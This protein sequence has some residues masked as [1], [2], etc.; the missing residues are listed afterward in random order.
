MNDEC[1]G[2]EC[3]A[4][5]HPTKVAYVGVLG[6]ESGSREVIIW[7]FQPMGVMVK[8]AVDAA[9]KEFPWMF[10]AFDGTV[11]PEARAPGADDRT[12]LRLECPLCGLTLTRRWPDPRLQAVV[13][14]VLDA[15]VSRL[16]LSDLVA[17]L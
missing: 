1:V 7:P 12:R 9:G 5:S 4:V 14:A 10:A 6:R 16:V 17:R 2:I 8:Q 15:G 3:R 13:N 11:S